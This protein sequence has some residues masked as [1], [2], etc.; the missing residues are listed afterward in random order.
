MFIYSFLFLLM[1][2]DHGNHLLKLKIN[3]SCKFSNN[4]SLLLKLSNIT[5]VSVC[6]SHLNYDPF[7][8]VY[9]TR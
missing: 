6:L 7:V 4:V 8:L 9:G 1:N 3:S 2:D 5:P